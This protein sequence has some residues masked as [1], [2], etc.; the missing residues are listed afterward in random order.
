[1]YSEHQIT[2]TLAYPK[3]FNALDQSPLIV[4]PDRPLNEVISLMGGED[5]KSYVLVCDRGSSLIQ[6]IFTERDGVKLAIKGD[7]IEGMTVTQAMTTGI[8]TLTIT[9]NTGLLTA[10]KILEKHSIRHLPAVDLQGNLLGVLTGESIRLCLQP[11]NLLKLRLVR[12]VMT[13]HVLTALP[14]ESILNIAHQILDNQVSCIVICEEPSTLKPFKQ[15]LGIVTEKD[16]LQLHNLE[17]DL[18]QIKAQSVM[19]SPLQILTPEESLWNAQNKMQKLKIRRLVI[20]NEDQSLAGILTQSNLLQVFNPVEITGVINTLKES[21]AQ[22]KQVL[23]SINQQLYNREQLYQGLIQN[24]P[25][26]AIL[27]FDEELTLILAD[28]TALETVGLVKKEIE[29]KKISQVFPPEVSA[30]I[31][32]LYRRTLQGENTVGELGYKS[33]IYLSHTQPLKTDHGVIIGG[34]MVVQD[35]GLQK[36]SELD[37]LERER[38]LRQV[39]DLVPHLIFAKDKQDNFL[40]VN[41]GVAEFYGTTVEALLEKK[42]SKTVISLKENHK[43]H[44]VD[45]EVIEQGKIKKIER[46]TLTDIK[47]NTRIFQTTKIPFKSPNSEETALLGVAIDITDRNKFEQELRNNEAAIRAL[48]KVTTASDLSF[49]ERVLQM[50]RMGCKRYQLEFGI[51]SKIKEDLYRIENC[52]LTTKFDL[53]KGDCFNLRDTY[54]Q[55]TIYAVDGIYFESASFSEWRKHPAYNKFKIEAYMGTKI[56]VNGAVYGTLNFSSFQPRQRNFKAVDKELLKLM[57]Q[58]IG[59]EIERQETQKALEKQLRRA[60]L[61]KKITQEIRSTLVPEEIFKTTTRQIGKAFNVSRCLIYRYK[62]DNESLELPRV[63]EYLSQGISSM[64]NFKITFEDYPYIQHILNQDQAIFTNNINESSFVGNLKPICEDFKVKAIMSIRTSSQGK[65]NGFICLHHCQKFHYW[66]EDEISLLEDIADQVGIAIEQADLLEKQ[67]QYAETL[68][69]KNLELNQA[70]QMA[71]TASQA[72]SDFL[73]TMS[74]EIRTPMNAIIGMTGLLH[75]TILSPEQEALANTIRDSGDTLLHIINDILDFSKIESGKLE[76]EKH[77]LDLNQVIE[78]VLDLISLS[79]VDKGLELSYYITSDTPNN[80]L[81]DETRLRQILLNLLS[82]AVKFTTK[83]RVMIGV[84]QTI[85]NENTSEVLFSVSDTGIGIPPERMNRLFKAFSQV[86]SSTT[87]HYGGTGLGLVISQSLSL[88]MGGKMWV[89]SNGCV[90]G[91]TPEKWRVQKEKI[92]SC[93]TH[94]IATTFYFTITCDILPEKSPVKNINSNLIN[95]EILVLINQ[96]IDR[97]ILTQNLQDWGIKTYSFAE[98]GEIINQLQNQSNLRL[99][100]VII[101]LSKLDQDLVSFVQSLNKL[102]N[103]E[104]IPLILILPIAQKSREM[105]AYFTK[106]WEEEKCLLISG[107]LQKPLKKTSLLLI[108]NRL[109]TQE[110]NKDNSSSLAP[111]SLFNFPPQTKNLSKDYPLKI[112]VVEDNMTNQKVALLMLQK[113]GYKA[114]VANNGLEAISALH[115]QDYDLLFMDISMPEMDGI[116]ATL[117]IREEWQNSSK[118]WIVAMTANATHSDRQKC[119]ESGMNDYISKPVRESQLIQALKNCPLGEKI[120]PI[121]PENPNISSEIKLETIDENAFSKLLEMIGEDSY[122]L[123]IDIIN[124]YL[125]DGETLIQ[126]LEEGIKNRDLQQIYH[127][128]HTL[129]SSSA[130]LGAL[131]LSKLCA[132]LEAKGRNGNIEGITELLSQLQSEYQRVDQ[133]LR[134]KQQQYSQ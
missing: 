96:P 74:H 103:V 71:D 72:K 21:L 101:D 80:L 10:L 22:K 132:N 122:E 87:R 59:S 63:A 112:L 31:E 43:F 76:I 117:G 86:D 131:K 130:T 110:V 19:I 40:L 13:P 45:L 1:M 134:Q 14:T 7:K 121:L 42:E 105:E 107:F 50:L 83:G 115:R 120:T 104:K 123:L 82:N 119:L 79:A 100:A 6:G 66:S 116:T 49:E 61:L 51:L 9:E 28:G 114:E 23:E 12:E 55:E 34:I 129:K 2:Q 65:A 108:L 57:A 113:L 93:Y 90:V 25:N 33:H 81:S 38:V 39:I 15:P 47:G 128:S 92:P 109:F 73:A 88:M 64:G 37:I 35:I 8:I 68:S 46:E 11:V 98:T 77:P 62:K 5:S 70:R 84:T 60:K 125:E 20:V 111:L 24:F 3:I 17:L 41:Q 27:V 36:K 94:N 75:D 118:P 58:W 30:Q 16:I 95:K 18:T 85:I 67:T 106:I 97:E 91:E 89:E 4:T 127:S 32:P 124:S 54:C 99:D 102:L 44:Q 48:Y 53:K 78:S 69:Q 56:M 133:M 126:E 52:Y 26:G 29:G